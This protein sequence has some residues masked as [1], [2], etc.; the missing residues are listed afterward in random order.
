MN[1][2]IRTSTAAVPQD[3]KA[4][5]DNIT[6]VDHTDENNIE[7]QIG[8]SSNEKVA[9]FYSN[10]DQEIVIEN[11]NPTRLSKSKEDYQFIGLNKEVRKSKN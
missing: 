4:T 6:T 8:S 7:D 10:K 1:I 5:T 11:V 9:R 3:T 2:D